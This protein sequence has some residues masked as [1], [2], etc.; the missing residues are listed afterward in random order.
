MSDSRTEISDL[1]EFG[2]IG[3]LTK[4]IELQNA[5]PRSGLSKI[6]II[7]Q[8]GKPYEKVAKLTTT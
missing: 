8:M 5:N 6:F 2:L 1:G 7:V 4:N 3:H